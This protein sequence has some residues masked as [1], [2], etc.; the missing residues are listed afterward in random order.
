MAL[1]FKAENKGEKNSCT[2]F[3]KQ[4]VNFHNDTNLK[5]YFLGR[6]DSN[7]EEEFKMNLHFSFEFCKC[8]DVFT[9]SYRSTP[10]LQDNECE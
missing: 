10:Q 5:L 2:W 6:Q 7:L 4:N 9:D 1:S 8:L 3:I